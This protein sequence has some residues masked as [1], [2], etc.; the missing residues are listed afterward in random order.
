MEEQRNVKKI[1]LPKPRHQTVDLARAFELLQHGRRALS[2]LEELRPPVQSLLSA[3]SGAYDY[4]LKIAQASGEA[5]LRNR[6]AIDMS[7]EES[8]GS[9]DVTTAGAQEAAANETRKRL[10]TKISDAAIAKLS[11]DA[12]AYAMACVEA[13]RALDA[14][15]ARAELSASDYLAS[16]T[17]PASLTEALAESALREEI[18]VEGARVLEARLRRIAATGDTDEVDR[19][20]RLSKV[21]VMKTCK[22]PR[23]K[24][25]ERLGEQASPN[26]VEDE[27]AAAFKIRALLEVRSGERRPPELE[28]VVRL[29]E[30]ILKPLFQVL[31]GVDARWL[32][33]EEFAR[34]LDQGAPMEAWAIDAKWMRRDLPFAPTWTPDA[35]AS[36]TPVVK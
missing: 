28:A 5:V 13:G 36:A 8:M 31:L 22:A 18:E 1:P 21:F 3:L 32:S 16:G 17:R 27:R 12:P 34:I 10:V 20:L 33:Q 26:A 19:L 30:T 11:A 23:A 24:I 2:Q 7:A 6:T 29:R 4:R 35:L 9:A 25:A 14:A 15:I